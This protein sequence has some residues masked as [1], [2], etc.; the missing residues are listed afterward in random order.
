M[1]THRLSSTRALVAC[2]AV[3][4]ASV[5]APSLA[6]ARHGGEAAQPAPRFQWQ[7]VERTARGTEKNDGLRLIRGRASF[8]AV[9]A[10][11]QHA[12]KVFLALGR[13]AEAEGLRELYVPTDK[14]DQRFVRTRVHAQISELQ[15]AREKAHSTAGVVAAATLLNAVEAEWYT[16]TAGRLPLTARERKELGKAVAKLEQ[17]MAPE[18]LLAAALQKLE[19]RDVVGARA[20]LTRPSF[21]RS[22]QVFERHAVKELVTARSSLERAWQAYLRAAPG[23]ERQQALVHLRDAARRVDQE[24]RPLENATTMVNVAAGTQGARLRP[25]LSAAV[26]SVRDAAGELRSLVPGLGSSN[27]RITADAKSDAAW[28][29]QRLGTEV[30]RYVGR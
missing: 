26:Y 27:A 11:M 16:F 19:A 22:V 1:S 23:E 20:L 6:Y 4:A 13:H 18:R 29:L 7:P 21:L 3:A 17:A 10:A 28:Q 5:C 12:V 2:L 9:P 24:L 25:E 14:A 15:R 30:D 8:R